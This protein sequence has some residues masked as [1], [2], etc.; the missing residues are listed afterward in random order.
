M[1]PGIMRLFLY[2]ESKYSPRKVQVPLW[3]DCAGCVE[4]W[5]ISFYIGDIGNYEVLL[6]REGSG[7]VHSYI[8]ILFYMRFFYRGCL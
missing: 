2:R 7:E 3:K 8:N 1:T 6:Y 4:C 5:D